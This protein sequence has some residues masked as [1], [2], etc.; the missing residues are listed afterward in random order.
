M[1]MLHQTSVKMAVLLHKQ[2]SHRFHSLHTVL[3]LQGKG[4]CIFYHVP[5]EIKRKLERFCLTLT[6]LG[7][8]T[9][10]LVNGI[11]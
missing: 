4:A 10:V 11:F 2:A 8:N 1:F 5:K 3:P 6:R 9:V 7:Y